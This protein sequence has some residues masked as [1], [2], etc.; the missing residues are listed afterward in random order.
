MSKLKNH[1][2][3]SKARWTESAVGATAE[4]REKPITKSGDHRLRLNL[5]IV[6]GG[7]TCEFVLQLLQGGS[8][9]YLDIHILGVC[10]INDKAE[11]MKLARKMGLYTTHDFREFFEMKDL[12]GILELTNSREVLLDLIRMRPKGI[13]VLEHN[14][15]R[16][17]RSFFAASQRL[18][19]VEREASLDKRVSGF[20]VQQ[21][22]ERILVLDPDFTI[23][24]VSEAFLNAVQRSREQVVGAACYEVTHR[25]NAPCSAANPEIGCPL[26]E[27][28]RTGESA[29]V[30]HEHPT[31]EGQLN[32]CDMVTYPLKDQDGQ[33][34][35]VIEIWRDITREL[36]S[37]WERRVKELKADLGK[38]VQE[39][40]LISLGKLVASSVHEINNPIQGLMTFCGLMQDM[41]KDASP[42]PRDLE[43][44]VYYLSVMD[45]ELDR[46]G[47]IVTG[48]LSFARQSETSY[49]G[50]DLN[51]IIGQVTALTRHRMEIQNI[52]LE[53][54]LHPAPLMIEGDLNQIQQCFLNLIFNAIEAMPGGGALKVALSLHE[55]GS[56]AVVSISDT[57]CGI[58]EEDLG[59][60]FDP[61]FTTKGEGEGTGMGLSIVHG[62]VKNHRG[63]ISVTSRPG[64]G[65]VF[66]LSFPLMPSPEAAGGGSRWTRK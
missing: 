63:S 13:G 14:I 10:D 52:L 36:A 30:I 7:K 35:R 3:R 60:I 22:K 26:V 15:G 11:G 53:V 2:R 44:F 29:H 48:L 20:L 28:L 24:E 25:L 21:T 47:R 33:V 65:A 43:K 46:C 37:R 5:A 17:L 59:H 56:L 54:Y 8:F 32:Y 18:G 61:F 64:Q 19:M 55:Q 1:A 62:I 23:R 40:R 51:E 12:N 27:T 45:R 38:L 57:G 41:L 9:P 49:R 42:L 58:P 50:L 16:L 31:P 6:G 39:D 34:V 4:T 66:R